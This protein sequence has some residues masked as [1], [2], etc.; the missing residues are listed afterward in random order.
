[1]PS[2]KLPDHRDAIRQ[3]AGAGESKGRLP[4]SQA[5]FNRDTVTG[6]LFTRGEHSSENNLKV[7]TRET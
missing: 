5:A 6:C 4:R 2:L 7:E 3:F 1:M